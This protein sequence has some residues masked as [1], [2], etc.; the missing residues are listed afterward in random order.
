MIKGKIAKVENQMREALAEVRETFKHSGNKGTN[1]EHIFGD[2]AR[3]YLP[4]RLEIGNGEI[5][6]SFGN[7]SGQADII[8]V[9]ED[10]PFTFTPNKPGLFFIE[11]ILSVGEIKT[12]L[13]TQELKNTLKNSLLY[14]K[15]K[16][17]HG[18]GSMFYANKSDKNRYYEHPPFFLFCYESQL[19]LPTIKTNIENFIAES[20]TDTLGIIDGVFVL[21]KGWLINFGDGKGAFKFRTPDGKNMDGWVMKKSNS[22]LFDLFSYISATMPK[23]IRFEPILVNYLFSKEQRTTK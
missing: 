10:H 15:L 3:K 19:T 11:G 23:T 14:K 5:I 2:F 20:S 4:R 22:V 17:T 7:R 13:T 1:I 16:T 6:D 18:K 12:T 8:I 9:N 21:D